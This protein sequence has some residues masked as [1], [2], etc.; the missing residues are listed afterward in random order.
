LLVFKSETDAT[1]ELGESKKKSVKKRWFPLIQNIRNHTVL[2][3]I[4]TQISINLHSH[5]IRVKILQRNTSH[6]M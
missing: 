5:K 3:V 6:K 1:P 2:S 4:T